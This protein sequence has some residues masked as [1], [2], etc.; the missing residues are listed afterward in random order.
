M[1]DK[2]IILGLMALVVVLLGGG[3]YIVNMFLSSSDASPRTKSGIVIVN[4]P[5]APPITE[6]EKPPEQPV[7]EIQK[8]VVITEQ[9]KDEIVDSGPNI[10]PQ[11]TDNTP[12]GGPPGLTGGPDSND[13]TPAGDRLG[14]DAEGKAGS[15]GFGLVGRKGGRSIL[16]GRGGSGGVGGG[17]S[18][19]SSPLNKF[20]WYTQIVKTEISK[21]IQKYLD[22]N[23][24]IPRGKLQTIVR[25]SVDSAGAVVQWRI[26][27]SSGN[28]DM[29]EAVKQCI[30]DVRISEPPPEGMPRTLIIRVTS[31]G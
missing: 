30:G 16:A 19:K 24:G 4:L 18:G 26:V 12:A 28:H 13:N 14:L 3:V 17:G 1:S 15:D 27:G 11:N 31:Q 23:G 21:K 9:E 8:K 22:E 29:D 25:I 10:G 5:K 2:K 6:K 7:K 20:G